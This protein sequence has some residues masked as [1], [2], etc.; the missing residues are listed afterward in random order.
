MY[1]INHCGDPHLRKQE[2]F[3]V[4]LLS[5]FK[6]QPGRLLPPGEALWAAVEETNRRIFFL[7]YMIGWGLMTKNTFAHCVLSTL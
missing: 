1:Q 3:G 2:D 4:L 6:V 5:T 7:F